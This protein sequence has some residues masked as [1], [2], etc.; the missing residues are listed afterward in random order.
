MLGWL[1]VATIAALWFGR[2]RLAAWWEQVLASV[3]QVLKHPIT[4]GLAFA[5]FCLPLWFAILQV[6]GIA[7]LWRRTSSVQ[8]RWAGVIVLSVGLAYLTSQTE[9]EEWTTL[10]QQIFG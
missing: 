5:F 6:I 8:L 2:K 4:I 7:I 9:G 3:I 10:F 1:L